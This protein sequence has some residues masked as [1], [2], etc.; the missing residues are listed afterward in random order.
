ML[1]KIGQLARQELEEYFQQKVYLD[2]FVKVE[3]DWR[4]SP[5]KLRELNLI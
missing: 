1:K 2:L 3:P 5:H 4:N